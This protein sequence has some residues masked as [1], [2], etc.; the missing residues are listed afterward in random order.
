MPTGDWQHSFVLVCKANGPDKG[1]VYLLRY[2]LIRASLQHE[3]WQDRDAKSLF[4]HG[5]NGVIIMNVIVN[6]WFKMIMIENR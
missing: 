3:L 1:R 5:H 6:V 2:N 4:Y